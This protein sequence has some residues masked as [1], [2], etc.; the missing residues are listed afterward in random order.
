MVAVGNDEVTAWAEAR[1][2]DEQYSEFVRG[3]LREML[4]LIEANQ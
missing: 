3:Q 4:R 2:D 1:K